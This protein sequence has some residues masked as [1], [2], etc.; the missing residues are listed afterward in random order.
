VLLNKIVAILLYFIHQITNLKQT[1]MKKLFFFL[2]LIMGFGLLLTVSCSKD[3]D[4]T[5]DD[6]GAGELP[7]KIRIVEHNDLQALDST[8]HAF[9]YN[10]RKLM[11]KEVFRDK[12]KVVFKVLK[13]EYDTKDHPVRTI[14]YQDEAMS[15]A[16]SN[17]VYTLDASGLVVKAV[18]DRA[19]NITTTD[20]T[21]NSGRL[22]EVTITYTGASTG[23]PEQLKFYW[24]N[25]N[26]AKIEYFVDS[27]GNG[28]AKVRYEEMEYD[29]KK[30]PYYEIKLPSQSP[31]WM[32]E[33]N[34]TK[35]KEY[36]P[37]GV[38]QHQTTFQYTKY[39]NDFPE[40]GY[41]DY[42]FKQGVYEYK[43]KEI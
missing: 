1:T 23:H 42:G 10:D 35:I 36:D 11:S 21:Y 7:K 3:D 6:G 39:K 20:Y 9:G 8:F 25:D 4:N 34:V 40:A 41:Y 37:S 19:G 14:E 13:H 17:T 15:I 38:L 27:T 12:N 22:S 16:A 18:N 28:F 32:S 30:N 29:A 33:N 31:V 43:Y 26:V 24:N 2:A 5:D